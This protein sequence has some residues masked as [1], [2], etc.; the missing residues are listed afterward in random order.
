MNCRKLLKELII[1]DKGT[2]GVSRDGGGGGGGIHFYL[3]LGIAESMSGRFV[4]DV[5][6]SHE[7]FF[8]FLFLMVFFFIH[9]LTAFFRSLG[10]R[11]CLLLH[12]NRK[13]REGSARLGRVVC[14]VWLFG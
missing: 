6:N 7:L 10:W 12:S 4:N 1:K 5:G 13:S 8:F 14:D 3:G 2:G 11:V 9:V